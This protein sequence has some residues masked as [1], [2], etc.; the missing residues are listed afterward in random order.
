ME[1]AVAYVTLE[2]LPEVPPFG[3]D[4]IETGVQRLVVSSVQCVTR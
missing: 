1:V 3:A 4:G 2:S